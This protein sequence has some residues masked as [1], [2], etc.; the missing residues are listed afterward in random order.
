MARQAREQSSR[1]FYHIIM[2][3]NNKVYIFKTDKHKKFFKECLDKIES[4][5]D[6]EVAAWC[7]MDNHVHLGIKAQSE[8]LDLA[9]KRLNTK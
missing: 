8:K 7:L 2:R 1:N 9:F 6:L 4:D 5:Q 3:G